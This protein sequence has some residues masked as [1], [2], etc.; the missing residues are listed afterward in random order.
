MAFFH[1]K[2]PFFIEIHFFEFFPEPV[3]V[4]MGG[5]YDII[6][7]CNGMG[8]VG[9]LPPRKYLIFPIELSGPILYPF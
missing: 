5:R 3:F 7:C 8:E 9:I 6:R 2:S 1:L 4:S